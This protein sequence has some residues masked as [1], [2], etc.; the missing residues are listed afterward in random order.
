MYSSHAVLRLMDQDKLFDYP[1]QKGVG[2]D[3]RP[4][5]VDVGGIVVMQETGPHHPRSDRQIDRKTVAHDESIVEGLEM[6]H[7]RMV[8]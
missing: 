5:A 4:D 6:H 3:M 2:Q 1:Q 7:A 8:A